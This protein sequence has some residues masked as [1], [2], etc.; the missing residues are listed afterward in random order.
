MKT[1]TL[2]LPLAALAVSA[3][4]APTPTA[5][6]VAAV[7]TVIADTA[8]TP[9]DPLGAPI[10]GATT[11]AGF[12]PPVINQF[13][14]QTVAYKAWMTPG[15]VTFA[16]DEG[17]WTS[18]RTTLGPTLV[19]RE[20]NAVPFSVPPVTYGNATVLRVDNLQSVASNGVV[21]AT[22]TSAAG[23][24]A[25]IADF[26]AATQRLLAQSPS[27]SW[28]DLRPPVCDGFR[29]FLRADGVI[30]MWV[31]QSPGGASPKG[32]CR[33]DVTNPVTGVFSGSTPAPVTPAPGFPRW[34]TGFGAPVPGAWKPAQSVRTA[35]PA[36]S[37]DGYVATYARPLPGAAPNELRLS[38][39]TGAWVKTIVKVGDTVTP[40]S[41]PFVS[42]PATFG[43]IHNNLM[44]V[45]NGPA[46]G[47]ELVT[48]Q[49]NNVVGSTPAA[50]TSLW[51]RWGTIFQCLAWQT[52]PAPDLPAGNTISSF[53]ELQAV[54][55]YV[56]PTSHWVFWGAML[57]AGTNVAIY[58]THVI[59]GFALPPDLIASD[60]PGTPTTVMPLSGGTT[61]ITKLDRFFSVNLAGWVLFKANILPAPLGQR[62]VLVTDDP[63]NGRR[64]RVQSGGTSGITAMDLARPEQGPMGRGQAMGSQWF[65]ARI[66]RLGRQTV[67]WYNGL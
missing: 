54:P 52:Q 16:D 49:M 42:G 57:N 19:L 59:A 3:H 55:S 56:T 33:F 45:S 6:P 5:P 38:D 62:Q 34:I 13:D 22:N 66:T 44:A 1:H 9:L 14:F 30:A 39:P 27:A 12:E 50:K 31:D 63:I 32:V 46:A 26:D 41:P 65:T 40:L 23:G 4:A 67:A 58:R 21:C 48:W 8:S 15:T 10:V 35:S 60:V 37:P 25:A 29:S 61:L 17:V 36:I 53:Y 11:Y 2:L 28:I 18:G 20:G 24:K 47:N 7:L 43:V 51:T 64:V